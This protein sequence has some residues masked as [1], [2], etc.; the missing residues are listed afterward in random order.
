MKFL[1]VGWVNKNTINT[2]KRYERKQDEV[3]G[4]RKMR[5]DWERWERIT[6][7]KN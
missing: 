5:R 3:P 4:Q 2:I 6:Y 1:H 7:N